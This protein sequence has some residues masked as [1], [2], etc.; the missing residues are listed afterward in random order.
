M[1]ATARFRNHLW[2]AGITYH[3]PAAVGSIVRARNSSRKLSE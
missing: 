3:G 2:F 1:R